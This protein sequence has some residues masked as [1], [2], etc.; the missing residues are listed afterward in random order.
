MRVLVLGGT[1]AMGKPLI[2]MLS[3]RGEEV[4]ITSRRDYESKGNIHY[5][6]GDAH[7]SYFIQKELSKKYDAIVDFMIYSTEEFRARSKIYLGST[8]Q[9]I[10]LSSARVYADSKDPITEKS[11]RLLDVCKDIGYL[12]TDEYALAKAR[13]ENIL[14]DS[15]GDNWTIIRPYI[16]YNVERLQL[17]A[18]E[19]DVWLYRALNS[20]SVPLPQ[21]VAQHQTTMT[22]GGDVAQAIDALVGNKRAYGEVFNLTG[23][24]HMKWSD[25]WEIYSRVLVEYA[26]IKLKLYQP[27]D[28]SGIWKVMGN[29]YQVCYDRMFDRIFDNSKL[30]SICP[31][32][33]FVTMEEGL[34]MCLHNFIEKPT[35]NSVFGCGA[36]AYLNKQTG[37]KMKLSE[38]GGIATKFRYLGYRWVPGIM[39]TLKGR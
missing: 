32:L 38:L 25:V 34:T 8:D 2:E 15:N 26:G 39:N 10:F 1:G 6:R 16:T 33:N 35:W 4:F 18:I 11:P 24:Q 22:Y 12:K 36:E 9:Y 30:L 37:E 13:S 23:T 21:D 17:G 29:E 27:D 3:E 31:D 19:K 7:D 20:R 5:I 28:S 14:F